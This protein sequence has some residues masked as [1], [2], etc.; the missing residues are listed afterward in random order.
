MDSSKLEKEVS[1]SISFYIKN[2]KYEE[3]I[4][5]AEQYQDNKIIQS[6]LITVYIQLGKYKEA[7][8]I[9]KKH[10]DDE[11]IQSQLITI[12]IKKEC[13]E[14]AI[15]I[16]IKHADYMPIQSQLMSIYIQIGEYDKAINLANKYP[17]YVPIQSQLMDVYIIIGE[18]GLATSIAKKNPNNEIIQT[19]FNLALKEN[20]KM[21]YFIKQGRN[22]I[23][24]S[25]NT[26]IKNFPDE[27]NDIR[28]KLSTGVISF[29]DFDILN[30]YKEQIDLKDYFLI[31][32][33]IY[34]RLGYWKQAI[35]ILKEDTILNDKL[36]RI[37][38]LNLPSRKN[39]FDL[40]KW[41]RLIGWKRPFYSLIETEHGKVTLPSQKKLE[42]VNN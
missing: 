5:L 23:L 14:E 29:K 7:L 31:K 12:Y 25:D 42:L 36:R 41:D 21:I 19:K 34:E 15:D 20:D 35:N 32:L 10:L 16:A 17:N 6:Q 8:E 22:Q 28:T 13:Y 24:S 39:F 3:A 1:K 4:M 30:R 11:V 9:I 26:T 38:L 33:A 2:L 37:L 40:G 18:Y 27:I